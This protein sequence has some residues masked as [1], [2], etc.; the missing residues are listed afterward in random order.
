MPLTLRTGH[1]ISP[2]LAAHA[3]AG[4]SASIQGMNDVVLSAHVGGPSPYGGKD[5][6]YAVTAS[7]GESLIANFDELLGGVTGAGCRGSLPS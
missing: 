6:C 4:G 3:A 1:S 7:F 2:P 5:R